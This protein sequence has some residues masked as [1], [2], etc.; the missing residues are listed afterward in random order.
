VAA[1]LLNE[2]PVSDVT[3]EE[4]PIEDVIEQAF[5]VKRASL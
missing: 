3:I 2:Q 1:K 5:A 4:Q